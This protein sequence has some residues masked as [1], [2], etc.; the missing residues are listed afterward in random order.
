MSHVFDVLGLLAPDTTASVAAENTGRL[1][2]AI[3]G[4]DHFTQ[5]DAVV[6]PKH[7][8]IVGPARPSLLVLLAAALMVLVVCCANVA[9]LLLGQAVDR[10]PEIAIRSA[11]GAQRPRVVRQLITESVL[12]GLLGGAGGLVVASYALRVL[13]YFAPTDLP[14]LVDAAIDHRAATAAVAAAL[15]SGL[16]FGL[17]P[18]LT[19]ARAGVAGVLTSERFGS[20][21][22]VRLQAAV[23]VAEV[24]I[25]T[26]LL[27]GAGLLT[28]SFHNVNAVD[29]GLRTDGVL[30]VTAYPDRSVFRDAE[31]EFDGAAMRLYF[32][33]LESTLEQLPGVSD[34]A[35]AQVVPFSGNFGRNTVIPEGH[36]VAAMNEALHADRR[37][38]S[39]N[40]HELLEVPLIEGRYLESD[41]DIEGGAPV[42]VVNHALAKRFWPNE[43]ALGKR[44]TWRD[45]ESV[46]VGVVGDMR[47][48][49][50]T[51]EIPL[52]FYAPMAPFNGSGGSVLMR[53]HGDPAALVSAVRTAVRE[54]DASLPI[55][56]LT[57]MDALISGTVASERYRAWLLAFLAAVATTLALAGLYGV[58]ARAVAS[59]QREFGIRIALGSSTAES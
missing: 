35:Q 31:G 16:M 18:A 8:E 42:V 11:L 27:M 50:L 32:R 34:V 37:F 22:R 23:I 58:T 15:L 54:F 12:V 52:Q 7:D 29:P 51:Q 14:R 3:N 55:V 4:V 33:E 48:L 28:L 47:D 25:A 53:T 46:I 20:R 10:R 49:D 57:P 36:E 17:A 45:R 43:S 30:S 5:H 38:V 21:G 41:D 59:R 2:R 13:V 44:L 19:L 1:L 24:A 6:V 9:T 39:P 26:L 40:F 56:A